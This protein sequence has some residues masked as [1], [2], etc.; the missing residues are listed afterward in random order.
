VE[1]KV[2]AALGDDGGGLGGEGAFEAVGVHGGGHV[3]VGGAVGHGGV[4]VVEQG[5]GGGIDSHVAGAVGGAAIDVVS[6]DGGGDAGDPGQGYGVRLRN[7][8]GEIHAGFVR[9]VDG[10]A[11]VGRSERVAGVARRHRVSPVAQSR[12]SVIPGRVRGGVGR[13]WAS[14][15]HG[16]SASARGRRDRAGNAER[17]LSRSGEIDARYIRAV[18]RGVLA[19]GAEGVAGVAGRDRVSTVGE[20]CKRVGAGTVGRGRGGGRS[21][22]RDGGSAAAGGGS[23]GSGN[24]ESVRLRGR[25]EI[26]TGDVRAIHRSVLA[27][28]SE[29]VTGVAGS[30]RIGAIRQACE[31]VSAGTVGR[32]R[33]GSRAAESD[34]GAAAARTGTNRSGNRVGWRR[35]VVCVLTSHKARATPGKCRSAKE[36]SC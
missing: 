20:T 28:G 17:G 32:T 7:G 33:G 24:A 23:D 3:K 22:E 34:S 26:E 8:G 25:G 2:N 6:G 15:G 16:G 36:R 5:D 18:D 9:G 31:A 1:G 11:L 29:R 30:N 21:T 13:S 35:R 14:E 19:G 27:C 10:D 12:K 4:G